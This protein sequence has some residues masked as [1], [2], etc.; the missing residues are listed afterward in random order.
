M[1]GL[2]DYMDSRV[3]RYNQASF[4][5]NDPIC[6]P[7]HIEGKENREIAAFL[8]ATMAWGQRQV[9]I[10]NA[11]RLMAMMDNEPAAYVRELPNRDLSRLAGFAHRTF[12]YTDLLFFIRAL[13][14]IYV[15]HGGLERVFTMAYG[16]YGQVKGML[17]HFR[18]VFFSL[19][20]EKRTEKH[21]EIGRASCRERV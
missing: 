15:N 11:M 13:H 2:K 14:N 19:P 7:H 4:I 3:A 5:D 10:R 21:V 9:I 12:Q 8:T 20:H 17:A 16:H 6:V 1:D 18:E